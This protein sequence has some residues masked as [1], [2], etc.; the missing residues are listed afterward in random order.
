MHALVCAAGYNIRW[1]LRAITRLGLA[2]PF[3]ALSALALRLVGAATG[4]CRPAA[5]ANLR[6]AAPSRLPTT[7]GVGALRA[8]WI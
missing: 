2:G 6:L 4:A 3:C 8:G 5:L 1:L 7:F